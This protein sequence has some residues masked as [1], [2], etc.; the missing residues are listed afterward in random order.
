V[1]VGIVRELYFCNDKITIN[2]FSFITTMQK[3][4]KY[5]GRKTKPFVIKGF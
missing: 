3:F 4:G 1:R 2:R 5:S